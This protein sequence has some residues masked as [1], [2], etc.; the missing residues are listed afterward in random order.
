MRQL[1]IAASLCLAAT[2][3]HADE[4]VIKQS[5][6]DVTSTADRME[7]VIE[8]SPAKLVARVDHQAA[9]KGAD[10]E[11]G[12]ATVLIFGNPALG[13]PLMQA[14]PRSAMDLPI[15]VLVWEEDGKTNIGYLSTDTLKER[16]SLDDASEIVDSM[17][18]VLD[19]L[20]DMAL[21]PN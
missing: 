19:R 1:L 17:A 6:S 3:S 13:T 7:A 10:L 2:A 15:R 8:A 5:T 21:Q 18:Q 12:P 9:A 11:M 4:W 16:Y 14:D 20:T